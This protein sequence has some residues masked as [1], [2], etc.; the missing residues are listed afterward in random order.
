MEIIVFTFTSGNWKLTSDYKAPFEAKSKSCTIGV[1]LQVGREV[2]CLVG[3][4]CQGYLW[5]RQYRR[6]RREDWA[7]TG[8]S[9]ETRVMLECEREYQ[10]HLLLSVMPAYIAAEV[11]LYQDQSDSASLYCARQVRISGLNY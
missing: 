1:C 3:G 2:V 6:D 5:A 7:I 11:R 4:L 9:L 10:E 8:W